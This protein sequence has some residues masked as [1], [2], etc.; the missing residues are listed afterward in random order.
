MVLTSEKGWPCSWG[1]YEFN[2]DCYVNCE[3]ERVW[4]IVRNDLSEW[5]SPHGRTDFTPHPRVLIGT[6]GIG[7]SMAAGSYLLYQLLHCDAE[8]LPMVAFFV[9]SKSFLFDKTSETVTRYVGKS[10]MIK[11]VKELSRRGMKGYIIYDVGGRLDIPSPCF[12]PGGWGMLVVAT[13]ETT[14]YIHWVSEKRAV[15]IIMNCPDER[16]V[17][18]MC[19]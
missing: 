15:R 13:P 7:K 19:V 8:Q 4:R 16:D 9:G 2:C 1:A 11:A 6:P 5:F 10:M 3:V 14:S 18:T 17:K 12:P